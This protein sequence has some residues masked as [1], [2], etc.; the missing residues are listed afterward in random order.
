ML[1]SEPYRYRITD[2]DREVF[3]RLVPDGHLLVVAERVI[4]WEGFRPLL[5]KFYF[6]KHGATRIGSGADV[7]A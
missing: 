1:V 6:C 5:E 4:D 2:F 7:E 3:R